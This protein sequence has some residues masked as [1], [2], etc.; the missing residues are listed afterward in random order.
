MAFKFE[1]VQRRFFK[2]P[3][4]WKLITS[5]WHINHSKSKKWST[6]RRSRILSIENWKSSSS[7]PRFWQGITWQPLALAQKMKK[8]NDKCEPWKLWSMPLKKVRYRW[9]CLSISIALKNQM[10]TIREQL[11][12]IQFSILHISPLK[13]SQWPMILIQTRKE[14]LLWWRD[15]MRYMN[16]S[17][18][19]CNKTGC[20]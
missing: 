15:R 18:S 13:I 2:T 20:H 10:I 9:M 7:T 8:T 6:K 11:C 1:Q 5:L 16:R 12:Q 4:Q 17:S 14:P 19:M 3:T